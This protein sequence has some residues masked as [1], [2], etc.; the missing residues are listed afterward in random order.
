MNKLIIH[1][2][3]FIISCA[4]VIWTNVHSKNLK[5]VKIVLNDM[6]FNVIN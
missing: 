6:L 5:R 1:K 3:R 4:N 2:S